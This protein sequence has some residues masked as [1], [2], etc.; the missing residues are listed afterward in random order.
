MKSLNG[1]NLQ[2]IEKKQSTKNT[3]EQNYFGKNNGSV[4]RN[5]WKGNNSP[6]DMRF[7]SVS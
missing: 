6:K 7:R 3:N 1:I 5:I 4:K 2:N